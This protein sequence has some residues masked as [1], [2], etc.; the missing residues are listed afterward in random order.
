MKFFQ[1]IVLVLLFVNLV[2]CSETGR[3]IDYPVVEKTNTNALE[4]YRVEV[5]DT[6]TILQMALYNR[7]GEFALLSSEVSLMGENDW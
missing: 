6:A 4:L 7:P 2:A 3:V 1:H 5:S